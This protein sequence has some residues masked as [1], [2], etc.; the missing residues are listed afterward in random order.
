MSPHCVLIR[1]RLPYLR[2]AINALM[3][4]SKLQNIIPRKTMCVDY[5]EGSLF[6][7]N[8]SNENGASALFSVRTILYKIH[9]VRCPTFASLS[10][11]CM[12]T[13]VILWAKM[14][15][16]IMEVVLDMF[17]RLNMFSCCPHIMFTVGCPMPLSGMLKMPSLWNSVCV[18]SSY[19]RN[20]SFICDNVLSKQL[21]I[22]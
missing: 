8:C 22:Y 1:S 11:C 21:L 7:S 20:V 4:F 12:A 3:V 14:L 16:R 18:H 19:C 2:G 10:P 15:R 9:V 6:E 17:Q 5:S 13:C